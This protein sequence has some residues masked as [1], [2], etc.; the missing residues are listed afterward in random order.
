MKLPN[1]AAGRRDAKGHGPITSA[2]EV[3]SLARRAVEKRRVRKRSEAVSK[4]FKAKTCPRLAGINAGPE[5]RMCPCSSLQ[6]PHLSVGGVAPGKRRERETQ[7]PICRRPTRYLR[8]GFASRRLRLRKQSHEQHRRAEKLRRR[9]WRGFAGKKPQKRHSATT[10][11]RGGGSR[12]RGGSLGRSRV[13]PDAAIT[14]TR[15]TRKAGVPTGM[16]R[17]KRAPRMVWSG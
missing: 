1:L 13:A 11:R 3:A 8:C 6:P 4:L 12:I 10:A 16:R 14:D 2:A 9:A 7:S 17:R 15:F 5:L